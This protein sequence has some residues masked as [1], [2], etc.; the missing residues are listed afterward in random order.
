MTF[1]VLHGRV[2]CATC[3]LRPRLAGSR[4][5]FLPRFAHLSRRHLRHQLFARPNLQSRVPCRTALPIRVMS[6]DLSPLRNALDKAKSPYL[7]QH[8]DNPVA[9][10]VH[11]RCFLVSTE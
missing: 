2:A 4:G 11:L 8:K 1:S 10:S 6:T 3:D 9:V 5:M 7:L